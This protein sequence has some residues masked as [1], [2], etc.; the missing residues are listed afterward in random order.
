[1]SEPLYF[2]Y[3]GKT[4][5]AGER[6]HLLPYHCLDVAAVVSVWWEASAAI[7]RS[8]CQDADLTEDQ[9]RAWVL[10]FA[11]LHDYGKFD[12]RFQLKDSKTWKIL[13]PLAGE[14]KQLPS[15]R[16]CRE[17]LHGENGLSWFTQDFFAYF[18]CDQDNAM[19]MDD[20]EPAQWLSWK[21]WIE[22]AAGHHGHVKDAAYI[23]K[24]AVPAICDSSFA[25]IDR[26]ARTSWLKELA[27]LFLHP[28]GLS[29]N[30]SPTP[31]SPLFAGLCS[32]A[33]WLASRCDET[34]F[35]FHQEAEQLSRYFE[36]K[37]YA[38]ADR[39]FKLSGIN[40]TA[41][42]Y[43][44]VHCLL[45]D[46]VAPRLLQTMVD[47][48][49]LRSGLTIIEAPTGSGKTE[50]AIAYAWRLL[51]AGMADSLIFALPTQATA[52]A[53]LG[54]LEKL[55]TKLF[56]YSPNLLLAHG[57]ARFNEKFAELRL[58]RLKYGGE[59]DGWVQCNEWLAESRK[60]VF[61]GQIGVCT[62]DQVL[63][64]VLPVKHRFVRGFGVGRSVLIIDEVHAY[65]A[66]M[67]GLLE[68]VLRQQRDANASAILLSATLPATQKRQLCA[69]WQADEQDKTVPAPY[70]LITWVGENE[71]K[72]LAL[73]RYEHMQPTEVR[74]ECPRT[75]KME[76]DDDLLKRIV[77]AAESGAQVAVICNIV[78]T[79]QRTARLLREWAPESVELFHAR[80]R[81]KD[82][83]L[84][85]AY[86]I[87]CFGPDGSRDHGRILVA[88]Q[89]VE[90]SLDLDFDWMITQ[91]CPIDLLFQRM[92]RL[93]RHDRDGRPTGFTEPICTILLP[94]SGN[95]DLTGKIYENTRVLW[96]TEQ[97]LVAA[98]GGKVVFP[99]AYRDWIEA[100]YEEKSWGNEPITVE[101]GFAKYEQETWGK[102]FSA[103][104]MINKASTMSAL[105]PDD[106]ETITA[107]TRDGEMNLTVIPYVESSNGKRLLD[108]ELIDPLDEFR[109]SE[110]LARNSIGVPRSW[111][112][113]LK[114]VCEEVDETGYWLAMT[115]KGE[116]FVREGKTVIFK[117]HRDTGLEMK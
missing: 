65:D 10:F 20:N 89:V 43:G 42:S 85:E 117:Y 45:P 51:A 100:T 27:Q 63:I 115:E 49:P 66:Y 3:W 54:R 109:K 112:R 53:M 70:P 77:A 56:E 28:V 90:Q 61:L 102:H 74:I 38:D 57:S 111:G 16:D 58:K 69:V 31:R 30:G 44:G 110:E 93:H 32:V 76:P 26:A 103:K 23:V 106:D 22:A 18:E 87:Q 48:L 19:F 101:E 37:V 68:E 79:A 107:V 14:Y 8:F 95:Y 34:N 39:I 108:G 62:I 4:E 6:H 50:A 99:A 29:L 60:R 72:P 91:L 55:A 104:E 52:N 98:P 80:Y 73:T 24:A 78:D 36:N 97:L 17:Y 114:E 59:S 46:T 94:E 88:T 7:R 21:P 81:F 116:A 64:S 11:A 83:Q 71:I 9:V 105:P 113:W 40:G 35:L 82:R 13:Y 86:A 75:I 33:D 47:E 67:Y 84:K 1:M 2:R 92:G 15:E 96:R 41:R 5:K 12:V 25:K